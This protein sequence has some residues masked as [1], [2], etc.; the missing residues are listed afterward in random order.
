MG[1]LSDSPHVCLLA[2]RICALVSLVL[3]NILQSVAITSDF[4]LKT[5]L[6]EYYETQ[7]LFKTFLLNG[8]F[9]PY[10]S[11]RWGSTLLLPGRCS[12][13]LVGA[14]VLSPLRGRAV[15]IMPCA[16]VVFSTDTLITTESGH[17]PPLTPPQCGEVAAP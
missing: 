5:R 11:R 1:S 16:H 14:Q 8:F 2:V 4:L 12:L 10:F 7:I 15:G 3:F 17:S 6:F 13:L 9:L